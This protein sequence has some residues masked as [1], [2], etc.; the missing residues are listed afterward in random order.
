MIKSI[1]IIL[2]I[3]FTFGYGKSRG[4]IIVNRTWKTKKIE[5]VL[6]YRNTFKANQR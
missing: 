1:I 4:H 6:S 3:P 5:G 2:P